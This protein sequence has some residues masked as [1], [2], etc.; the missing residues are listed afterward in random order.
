MELQN[1]I[2]GLTGVIFLVFYLAQS[3][4]T[5]LYRKQAVKTEGVV[6][7]LVIGGHTRPLCYHPIVK[8][9]LTD[10][11]YVSHQNSFGSSPSLFKQ[12]EIVEL[13]YLPEN[14][15][16]FIILSKNP[17]KFYVIFLILGLLTFG[18]FLFNL[19]NELLMIG[20]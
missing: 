2:I 18:Y 13:L 9:K 15:A 8:F 16:E 14:P 19:V 5:K 17:Q 20:K 6:T 7:D 12:G 4:K 3:V 10:G 1:L 11:F